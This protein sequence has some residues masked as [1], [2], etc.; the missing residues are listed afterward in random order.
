M[1]FL[2]IIV[3]LVALL[4]TYRKYSIISIHCVRMKMIKL[5]TVCLRSTSIR[6]LSSYLYTILSMKI[7]ST[8]WRNLHMYTK[9]MKKILPP[10]WHLLLMYKV[11]SATECLCFLYLWY[12]ISII[13][14]CLHVCTL[15]QKF[16]FYTSIQCLM[17]FC[18]RRP[19]YRNMGCRKILPGFFCYTKER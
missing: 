7:P 12:S 14:Y 8:V 19:V 4:Q 17:W 2:Y 3:T 1:D 10:F 18:Y 13:S 5:P 11:T 6:P 15:L 9:S 16:I